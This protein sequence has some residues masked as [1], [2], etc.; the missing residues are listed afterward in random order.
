MRNLIISISPHDW[1]ERDRRIITSE[2]QRDTFVTRVGNDMKQGS[3]DLYIYE[4][5]EN[6]DVMKVG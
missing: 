5:C 1:Q 3:P 6:G 4:F 2:K